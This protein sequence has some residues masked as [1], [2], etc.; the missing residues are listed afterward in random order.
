M[1]SS[2]FCLYDGVPLWVVNKSTPKHAFPWPLTGNCSSRSWARNS[3]TE[4]AV[5]AYQDLYDNHEGMLDDMATFWKR[6]AELFLHKSS[7]IGYE[8]I[9]EPFAGDFYEDPAI[10]MP[11]VAGSKNLAP[12]YAAYALFLCL[13]RCAYGHAFVSHLNYPL[14]QVRKTSQQHPRDRR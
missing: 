10:M 14:T 11:G 12:M 6:S 4:A 2:K 7:V 8:L 3:A 1:L 9:N 5:H 13:L